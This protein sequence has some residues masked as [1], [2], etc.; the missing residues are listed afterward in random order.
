MMATGPVHDNPGLVAEPHADTLTFRAIHE[1]GR[2]CQVINCTQVLSRSLR[3]HYEHHLLRAWRTPYKSMPWLRNACP[4]CHKGLTIV[5]RTEL[6]LTACDGADHFVALE[7]CWYCRF[8]QWHYLRYDLFDRGG[9][10]LIHDYISDISKLQSF[11]ID[12]PDGCS[13]EL[14]QRLRRDSRLW[15]TVDPRR[16]ELLVADIYRANFAHAEVVH[17]GR[18]GDGG[19]DV[20]FIDSQNARWL[21]QVKR[22]KR[23]LSAEGV[24]TLR[25]LL[26]TLVLQDSRCGAVVTT[27]DH[28]S[29]QAAS[30]ARAA[31]QRGFVIE[32][33]DRHVL[34]R[35]L[36]P[37][38]PVQPW[39][40]VIE[41]RFPDYA[42]QLCP[43]QDP[44]QIDMFGEVSRDWPNS[45]S[46]LVEVWDDRRLLGAWPQ[47]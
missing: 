42:S 3:R 5:E 41:R 23:P 29:Y 4:Y 12:L 20:L 10:G 31:R 34:N 44:R 32:L 38:L 30:A 25:S 39:R 13:I 1:V 35:L 46:T 9:E 14:A 19:T 40:E 2:G 24:V 15:H 17:I 37:L 11:Q 36:E 26:G 45:E 47:D 22:R 8:W 28:F 21:I 16:M 43:L 18:T 7:C 27:A 33:I 6:G